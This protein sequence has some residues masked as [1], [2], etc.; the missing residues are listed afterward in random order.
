MGGSAR[1]Q[2]STITPIG[3]TEV[4]GA[5]AAWNVTVIGTSAAGKSPVFAQY[6]LGPIATA[7]RICRARRV[8]GDRGEG[9]HRTM[10]VGLVGLSSSRSPALARP[11]GCE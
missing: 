9:I 7:Q 2:N 5:A 10:I 6:C 11:P 3:V 4:S 8:G 1:R